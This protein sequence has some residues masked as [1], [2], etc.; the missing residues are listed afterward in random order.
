MILPT[1]LA[2]AALA[3]TAT[4][5]RN[6]SGYARGVFNTTLGRFGSGAD[7]KPTAPNNSRA[8]LPVLLHQAPRDTAP[9]ALGA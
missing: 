1:L 5:N 3:T 4:V 2:A 8:N 6:E 7:E 9:L